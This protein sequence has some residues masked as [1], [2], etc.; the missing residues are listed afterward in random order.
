MKMICPTT[1]NIREKFAAVRRELSAALIERDE[2]VDLVLTAFVASEHI[3]LVGPPRAAR[4][5]RSYCTPAPAP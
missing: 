1:D 5:R 2:E 3:L 4:P